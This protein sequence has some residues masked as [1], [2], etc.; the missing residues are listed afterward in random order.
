[1]I[2]P[3]HP[4]ISILRQCALVSINRSGFYYRPTGESPLNLTLMRLID[5]AFLEMPW[6]G[7]RQMVR[8]LCRLGYGVGRKRVRRLM[9][10]MGLTPI[11][12]KPRTTIPH[13][14]QDL[15]IPAARADDR[16]AEPG[17]VR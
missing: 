5:E 11:Y 9:A 16:P 10:K 17:L 2:E 13:P 7:S 3:D 1:M 15:Q 14:A 8:H 12:Q 4:K 6:Y